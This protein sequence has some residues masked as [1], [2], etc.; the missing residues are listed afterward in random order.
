MTIPF[1]F[2]LYSNFGAVAA[3]ICDTNWLCESL[4]ERISD[5]LSRS[6]SGSCSPDF[7]GSDSLLRPGA[8]FTSCGVSDCGFAATIIGAKDLGDGI[9][10]I[11]CFRSFSNHG[12]SF[13]HVKL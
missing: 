6:R 3:R 12:G 11:A 2:G 10:S 4:S 8:C 1:E 13:S 7:T 5:P 9:V